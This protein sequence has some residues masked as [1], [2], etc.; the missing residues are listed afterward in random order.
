[1]FDKELERLLLSYEK[2]SVNE[3]SYAASPDWSEEER[4]QIFKLFK[5]DLSTDMAYNDHSLLTQEIVFNVHK[6]ARLLGIEFSKTLREHIYT[7]IREKACAF[8]FW[9][10]LTYPHSLPSLCPVNT[11]LDEAPSKWRTQGSTSSPLYFI[12]SRVLQDMHFWRID[13]SGENENQQWLLKWI[14]H[15]NTQRLLH[16]D[17]AWKGHSPHSYK[18]WQKQE[19]FLLKLQMQLEYLDSPDV[20]EKLQDF[21]I[22]S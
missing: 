12:H 7:Q 22:G 4:K 3:S 17:L 6:E 1:M 8:I 13:S 11:S 9:D 5:I 18:T 2:R 16:L 14:Y 15:P 20:S 19:E 10:L 21:A